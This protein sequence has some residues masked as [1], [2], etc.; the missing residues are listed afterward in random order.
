MLTAKQDSI[1]PKANKL[2]IEN[3]SLLTL[4]SKAARDSA[5]PWPARYR[6]SAASHRCSYKKK[7]KRSKTEHINSLPFRWQSCRFALPSL[8]WGQPSFFVDFLPAVINSSNSL[9]LRWWL[10]G[11]E[12]GSVK[13]LALM[14]L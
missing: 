14:V 7:L 8:R 3:S 10:F 11:F 5:A 4:R 2:S 13:C 1:W 12:V 9:A 6:Q